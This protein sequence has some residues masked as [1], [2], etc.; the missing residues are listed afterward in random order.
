MAGQPPQQFSTEF[1][2]MTAGVDLFVITSQ[3]ELDNQPQLRDYL[4][5]HYPVFA[6]DEDN[7]YLIYN[8]KP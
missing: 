1:A 2:R 8:L 5:A 7:G 6:Q 3:Q 4:A